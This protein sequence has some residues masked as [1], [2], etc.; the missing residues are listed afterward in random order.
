MHDDLI[1]ARLKKR[2]LQIRDEIASLAAAAQPRETLEA[3][4]LQG[5]VDAA[6]T[7]RVVG[8]APRPGGGSFALGIFVTLLIL[9]ILVLGWSDMADAANQ[10]LAQVYLLSLV[11]TAHG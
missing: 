4:I 2:R 6:D 10:T 1:V 3:A 11:A 5:D 9:A 7:V 8:A